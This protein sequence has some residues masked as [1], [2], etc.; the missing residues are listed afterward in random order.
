MPLRNRY[1]KWHY[2]FNL[3]GREYS[4]ATDW[5]ATERNR[6]KAQDMELEH[7]RALKE[8][9]RP[10]HQVTIRAFNDAVK[11]FMEWAQVEYRQHPNSHR[12]LAVSFASAKEFFGAMPVSLIDAGQIEKYK[13]WRLTDRIEGDHVIGAVRDVTVRHDLHGLSKFFGFAIAQHWTNH[14][15]VRLVKIPSDAD[16]VRM[17]ILTAA[18]EQQYFLRAAAYPDLYDLG[19]LVL[20]QGMRPEEV[21]KLKKSDVDLERGQLHIRGG[22]TKAARRTLTLTAESTSILARRVEKKFGDWI[23]PSKRSAGQPVARINNA[24]DK[25]LADAKEAGII[26]AF[27]PYDFRHTFATR[28]AQLGIDLATLAAIIGHSSLRIVQRYIHPTLEH[29]KAEMLKFDAFM[30]SWNAEQGSKGKTN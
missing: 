29:Q 23:F 27:V 19:R 13:T 5:D 12:R 22:K 9:R 25:V 24:H 16:A 10:Q 2:R 21:T 1:G 3:D 28:A 15:P 6:T 14:N 18:E 17:H 7:R 26:F 20:N 30:Q 11:E 4:A 8:G